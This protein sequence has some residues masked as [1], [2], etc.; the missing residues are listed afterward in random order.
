[1]RNKRGNQSLWQR[2][3]SVVRWFYHNNSIGALST[4]CQTQ[5][6]LSRLFWLLLF[7]MGA[8]LTFYGISETT[9]NY[10]NNRYTTSTAYQYKSK[11]ML[12]AMTIC[13]N[14]R[15]HCTNL[16]QVIINT[17]VEVRCKNKPE[18]IPHELI[19]CQISE[20]GGISFQGI[21]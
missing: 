20:Q 18:L 9:K 11:M 4:A 14:N 21:K 19:R 7:L 12:P 15:I 6:T 16:Y 2:L 1:M 10:N 17:T 3:V 13:N 8:G 5:P